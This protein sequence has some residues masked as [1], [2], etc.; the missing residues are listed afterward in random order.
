MPRAFVYMLPFRGHASYPYGRS[1]FL[2]YWY[3]LHTALMASAFKRHLEEFV[4]NLCS[5]LVVYKA[6]RHNE[7]VRVVVLADEACNLR[8]PCNSGAYAVVLVENHAYALS[9][10]ADTYSGINLAALNAFCKCMSE[11]GVVAAHVTVCAVILVR[12]TVLFKILYYI[13]LKWKARVVASK[14]DCL[15]FH[16]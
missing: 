9:A 6:T 10:S 2:Y 14:S 8:L 5:C 3:F 11:V 4:H 12:I 7:Y 15:Y 13:L 1:L 16:R